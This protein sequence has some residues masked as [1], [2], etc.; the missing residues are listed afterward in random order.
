[1][2]SYLKGRNNNIYNVWNSEKERTHLSHNSYRL[3][4]RPVEDGS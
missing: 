2:L 1:M 4:T 3:G